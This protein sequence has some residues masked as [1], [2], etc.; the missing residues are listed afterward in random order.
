MSPTFFS[1][2]QFFLPGNRLRLMQQFLT[3]LSFASRGRSV[4]NPQLHRRHGKV[5]DPIVHPALSIALSVMIVLLIVFA[6]VQPLPMTREQRQL[7]EFFSGETVE[8]SKVIRYDPTTQ[9]W[10]VGNWDLD[11][12]G[13]GDT[14]L[15]A[16][17]DYEKN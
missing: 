3:R 16:M 14:L 10:L 1:G 15:T 5:R 12:T 7:N 4:P 2:S 9:K 6:I 17:R 11:Q 13:E 8:A